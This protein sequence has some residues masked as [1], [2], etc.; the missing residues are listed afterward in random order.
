MGE[1]CEECGGAWDR[2][3]LFGYQGLGHAA[4]TQAQRIVHAIESELNSRR[5]LRW[6][7]IDHDLAREIRDALAEIVGGYLAGV[8]VSL[9]GLRTEGEIREWLEHS[10][11]NLRLWK[12]GWLEPTEPDPEERRLT[13]ARL[14]AA[15]EALE[16]V[17]RAD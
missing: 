11:E 7:R 3:G 9:S 17:L 10:R 4:P 1:R 15:I 6:D 2:P 14:E 13:V 16:W 5:G 12:N 8:Q